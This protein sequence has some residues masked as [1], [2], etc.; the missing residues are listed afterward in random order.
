MSWARGWISVCCVSSDAY[1]HVNKAIVGSNN[2]VSLVWCLAII[3]TSDGLSLTGP[4][5]KYFCEF[6]SKHNFHSR[7]WIW[8]CR[9][10]NVSLFVVIKVLWVTCSGCA[11][12]YALSCQKTHPLVT[13][14]PLTNL[15][16]SSANWW[17]FCRGLN[18]LS[19]HVQHPCGPGAFQCYSIF[20]FSIF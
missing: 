6:Q 3:W 18:V 13:K 11:I 10:Q 16:M 7:K 12:G 4:L 5:G 15:Q 9:M 14:K 17:P 2:G 20:N 1:A 19:Q 8:K